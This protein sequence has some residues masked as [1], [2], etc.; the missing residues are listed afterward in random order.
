MIRQLD[1]PIYGANVLFLIEPSGEEWAGFCDNEKNKVK[2]TEEEIK[3]VFNEIASD[4][5]SGTTIRLDK[6][7]YVFLIKGAHNPCY[8]AHE[9]YHVADRILKD[10]GVEHTDDDEAYAYMVGW[11]NEQYHIILQEYDNLNKV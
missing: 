8:F 1:I 6:G 3:L 2:L 10:R 4:K 5:W 7:G 11:L 9:L